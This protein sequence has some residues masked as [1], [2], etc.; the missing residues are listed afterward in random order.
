MSDLVAL[1]REMAGVMTLRDLA[2]GVL[3]RVKT[4][5]GASDAMVFA[6][7]E[8]GFPTVQG[9]PFAEVMRGYTPDMFQEDMLQAYSLSLPSDT[10]IIGDRGDFD[11]RGH[12]RSRPYADFYRPNGI[13]Y[14]Y[15]L[16]PTGIRYAAPGMF[17]VFLCTPSMS[18]RPD[19][20][21]LKRLGQL[22]G[23]MRVAARRMA[24]FSAVENERDVLRRLIGLERGA[25]VVW[26]QDGRLAW[27][28]PAAAAFIAGRSERAELHRVAAL[29]ARQL[30][31]RPDARPSL[32]ARPTRIEP[33]R[34]EAFLAE[35]C[36]I[37]TA[38]GRPWLVAEVSGRYGPHAR[39]AAL[40]TAERRVLALL[41]R[42]L[43]NREIGAA[44][45][46]STETV[47]THVSRILH[48]LA[49]DSRSKA[50]SLARQAWRD[51]D[52]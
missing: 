50:A 5:A 33:R 1:E 2:G 13:G 11:F 22:E 14:V 30:R 6:F 10:F 46:V 29:A 4:F 24:R 49:V 19:A 48:K 47:R 51:R 3:D 31:G 8:S 41:A 17:G 52:W 16:W 42:G 26:D 32:F 40:T 20:A 18:R 7:D 35:F 45:F 23:S 21:T 43:G 27:A 36:L 37:P 28:S 39:L 25:F 15:A 9:G 44:L 34:G 38:E 12:V